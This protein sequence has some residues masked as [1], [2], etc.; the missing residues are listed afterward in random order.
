MFLS[1]QKYWMVRYQYSKEFEEYFESIKNFI[2]NL[3]L[4]NRNEFK[5]IELTK[6][7]LLP[8][9]YI[10]DFPNNEYFKDTISICTNEIFNDLLSHTIKKI[11][12][13]LSDDFSENKEC[14]FKY[15]QNVYYTKK[16]IEERRTII[17][18]INGQLKRKIIDNLSSD[19]ITFLQQH[20]NDKTINILK[21]FLEN[22]SHNIT[23][24][25][26][27]SDPR[28]I[29]FLPIKFIELSIR[30]SIHYDKNI[31][32][33]TSNQLKNINETFQISIL[34]SDQYL[35]EAYLGSDVVG[36]VIGEYLFFYDLYPLLKEKIV[37]DQNIKYSYLKEDILLA[38]TKASH[39]S[40]KINLFKSLVAEENM[41]GILVKLKENIYISEEDFASCQEGNI[42]QFFHLAYL[43]ETEYLKHNQF[44]IPFIN[45]N[46]T[47]L[48]GLHN[49]SNARDDKGN[50]I[51]GL[52]TWI[53]TNGKEQNL[54]STETKTSAQK[55]MHLLPDIAFYYREKFFE[56]LLKDILD[57]I[58]SE[59]THL[60][61]DIIE[62][63]KFHV[64]KNPRITSPLNPEASYE[65]NQEFDFIVNYHNLDG[66]LSTIIIEAKTKLSKF[67]IQDQAEKVEKYIKNDDLE[68]FD[69]YF[70][71]GFNIDDNVY[72]AMA[73]F[74]EN[75]SID[76]N[77]TDLAFKYPLPTTKK[78][79]YCIA[80]HDKNTL[81]TN[82]L[83][84]F[85]L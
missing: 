64:N 73:Y 42:N 52:K 60:N 81:K 51:K 23:F 53:D 7:A 32:S 35:T 27:D 17:Q 67:V 43:I 44:F 1:N 65:H 29:D 74:I 79:L 54:V 68:I 80:S 47:S 14:L 33:L 9:E 62:N 28:K 83:A 55:V 18:K 49:N 84:L 82:L 66:Q 78:D 59:N 24:I 85:N 8:N 56:D 70:L 6:Y 3:I 77:P 12:S 40:E 30:T 37:C 4:T 11:E 25:E 34:A 36:L 10:T 22:K 61:L 20:F 45:D 69:K 39:T 26:N 75:L 57:E 38:D 71:I 41:L 16:S 58:K 15:K 21:V 5:I 63:K 76:E 13:I 2:S 48:F 50:S 31:Y 19:I 46:A 72:S